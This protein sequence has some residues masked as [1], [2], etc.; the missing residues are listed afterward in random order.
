MVAAAL[1]W[2]NRLRNG[3]DSLL[4]LLLACIGTHLA[5]KF[6]IYSFV[7]DGEVRRQMNTFIGFCYG[8][9]L[10]LY[11]RKAA[12]PAFI[13]ASKW[14]IFLPFIIAAIAYFTIAGLLFLSHDVSAGYRVLRWY[15][16]ISFWVL[17]L[18]DT[19]FSFRAWQLSG[20]YGS[21]LGREKQLV[22][23]MV[24]FFATIIG[25][26]VIFYGFS[27]RGGNT[28]F[29]F[30]RSI[31]YAILVGL[32]V[33][34]IRY[35]YATVPEE[36]NRSVQV[37][38]EGIAA[39]A[40]P[41]TVVSRDEE[42]QTTA[43]APARKTALSAEEQQRTWQMLEAHLKRSRIFA[44]SDLSLDKLALSSGLNKYHI[45]ETLNNYAQKSFYQY[46]N[47]YRIRFVLE[48][49]QQLQEQELP[50]NMLVLAYDAGYKAKSSFN[51]YFKEITG[52][53]PT[54]YLRSGKATPDRM[55]LKELTNS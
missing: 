19:F 53:T 27:F 9:L 52:L 10:Y 39:D 46:I 34:I 13:P 8:P 32:S 50:V 7:L 41:V 42:E 31:I 17:L 1:L 28:Y 12:E 43:Y 55:V 23:R 45:S 2:K 35:R 49:M 44:D 5:I 40:L 20:R 29:L 26:S 51:R 24:L 54:E 37:Q 6:V 11:A 47:E 48:R 18:A 22:R 16:E 3:A 33:T 30:F 15:N 14:Y 38:A 25:C 36:D 21:L 4:I